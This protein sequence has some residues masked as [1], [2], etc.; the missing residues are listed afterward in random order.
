MDLYK[1]YEYQYNLSEAIPFKALINLRQLVFE[2]TS[3]CNLRC[4][5]CGYGELYNTR[6][7][8]KGLN[9]KFPI[10]KNIIDYL[11]DLWNNNEL[12]Y[13]H[14][15][16]FVGFYGGEPLL[17]MIFI[18]K[19]IEYINSL[20]TPKRR[21]F[22]YTM[23][24]NGLILKKHMDYLVEKGFTLLISLDGDEY[25]HSYRIDRKGENS[26][27]RVFANVKLFQQKYPDYFSKNVSFN[28]VLTNR[29]NVFDIKEFIYENFG[30][31]PTVSEMNQYGILSKQEGEFNKVFH[32]LA[33]DWDNPENKESKNKFFERSPQF[34]VLYHILMRLSGNSFHSYNSLLTTKE[35]PIFPTGTCFPFDRK[36]FLTADG[37]I[38]PCERINQKFVLG[39]VT[40]NGVNIN[41]K[42]I[43]E[44][45][46]LYYRKIWTLCETCYT[47]PICEQ[48]LFY[49]DNIED[50][51]SCRNY[52][53]KKKY[54]EFIRS[55]MSYLIQNPEIYQKMMKE[56]F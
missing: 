54:D 28:A 53:N 46:S 18:K 23:T 9:L 38:L 50:K 11:F 36:L 16:T 6:R 41:Y 49:V 37:N 10:A 35:T 39:K 14:R 52:R 22:S 15:Q 2:V 55:C 19:V 42:E 29:S 21:S 7:F 43:A 17:N 8:T 1:N 51:P 48:C 56:T 30:K 3:N 31:Y 32:S 20:P 5:Y 24:T 12:D 45:Y 27:N 13:D 34:R 26:F 4:E 25:A 40:E 33:N 47:K 44:K